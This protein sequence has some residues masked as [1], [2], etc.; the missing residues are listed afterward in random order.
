MAK[1]V[2]TPPF[3]IEIHSSSLAPAMCPECECELYPKD[4]RKWWKAREPKAARMIEATCPE[5]NQRLRICRTGDSNR[6]W[7]IARLS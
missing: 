5:C 1:S 7:G 4:L 2:K 3:E 6:Y